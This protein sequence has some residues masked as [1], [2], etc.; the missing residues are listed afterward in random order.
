M[1]SKNWKGFL[2]TDT[3]NGPV[4]VIRSNIKTGLSDPEFFGPE[5][6]ELSIRLKKYGKICVNLDSV[7]YHEVA[8]S[9]EITGQ[10]IRKYY[11]IKSYIYFKKIRL[12]LLFFWANI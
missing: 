8:K 9:A 7:I 6:M 12:V 2:S 3:L 5:D 4:S 11:E 10:N 1:L